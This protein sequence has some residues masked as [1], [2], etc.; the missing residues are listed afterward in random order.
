MERGVTSEPPRKGVGIIR[1]MTATDLREAAELLAETPEASHWAEE[2][3]RGFLSPE[4]EPWIVVVE[5]GVAG[6][7][8]GRRAADEFEIL[9]LAVSPE[10]RRRGI[11]MALLDAALREANQAGARKVFL[12]VRASNTAAIEFYR[13]RGFTESGRRKAY[14]RNPV[15]DALLLSRILTRNEFR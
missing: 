4:Y 5:G 12:E 15:E 14:Y 3:L 7:L 10:Y 9:D 1:G 13:A 11:A 6:L 8:I 2:T